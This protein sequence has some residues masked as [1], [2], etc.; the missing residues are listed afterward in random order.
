MPERRLEGVERDLQEMAAE[1]EAWQFDCTSLLDEEA[2]RDGILTALRDLRDE[3]TRDH[4]IVIYYCGHGGR[5]RLEGDERPAWNYLV[6][7]DH[8][9]EEFRGVAEVELADLLHEICERTPNATV[10]LDCCHAATMCRGG[11][12]VERVRS[13]NDVGSERAESRVR[14]A[15]PIALEALPKA[16][17]ERL[18][19][20]GEPMRA[21]LHPEGHPVAVR[22]VATGSDSSAYEF[23]D[24]GRVTGHAGYRGYFTTE[25]CRALAEGRGSR[26]PWETIIVRARERILARRGSSTQRPQ[27]EGP[28]S[29]LPF[30]LQVFGDVR[31]HLALIPCV[32]RTMWVRAGRLHGL[33][34]GDPLALIDDRGREVGTAEVDEAFEDSARLNMSERPDARASARAASLAIPARYRSREAIWLGP[35]AERVDG[36]IVCVDEASRLRRVGRP[37]DALFRVELVSGRLQLVGPSWLSRRP[38]SIDREGVSSLVSDLEHVAR[39]ELLSRAIES[40]PGLGK[41]AFELEVLADTGT[42]TL[43]P[44]GDR[45]TVRV[46][47]RLCARVTHRTEN[48]S[49]IYVNVLG[50]GVD[51]RVGLISRSEPAGIEVR[52]G[53]TR[54]IGRRSGGRAGLAFT[55]PR[56]VPPAE[57]GR[58]DLLFVISRRALDLRA[59]CEEGTKPIAKPTRRG[60]GE[61][62]DLG[63]RLMWTSVR[64]ELTIADRDGRTN[65][66][67]FTTG[68]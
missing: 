37:D 21:R 47:E 10:I 2:T 34:R 58:G 30:S 57:R 42:G 26:W 50:R 68:C 53:E 18:G 9:A 36:L 67:G 28:R 14:E 16:L 17:R 23:K 40:P 39:A 63:A 65:S 41:V 52:S 27:L 62:P 1:L 54:W 45:R 44:L 55:W 25:L 59:W 66:E 15:R 56:D 49:P 24:D 12:T 29:R 60:A 31:E 4:C 33:S 35:G 64:L 22:L 13:F 7:V 6:P 32:D 19:R 51:R 11:R 3:T 46:G 8:S 5:R 48:K 38:W 20:A 61:S 43:R